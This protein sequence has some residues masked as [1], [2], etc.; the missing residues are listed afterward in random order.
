MMVRASEFA[1]NAASQRIERDARIQ[2]ITML[3][4]YSDIDFPDKISRPSI[5]GLAVH[6]SDRR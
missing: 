2:I 6:Q 4:E 3:Q 1:S 5:R